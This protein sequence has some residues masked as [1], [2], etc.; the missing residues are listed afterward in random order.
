MELPRNSFS[1]L[2]CRWRTARARAVPECGKSTLLWHRK[3]WKLN[4]W[5]R[6]EP[7]RYWAPALCQLL[8]VLGIRECPR[9]LLL[10]TRT[11]APERWRP[12]PVG[13]SHFSFPVLT[14]MAFSRD[15][16]EMLRY[17]WITKG[18]EGTGAQ[19]RQGAREGL[20]F[21]EG[22]LWEVPGSHIWVM[23]YFF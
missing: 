11:A 23:L 21:S 14:R 16:Q 12:F 4:I 7:I 9:E 1:L 10:E 20:D 6:W 19:D 3:L 5:N 22:Q 17:E 18:D 15:T 8:C 2:Y 13:G